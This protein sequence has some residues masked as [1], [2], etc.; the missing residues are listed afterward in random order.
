MYYIFYR[1][2]MFYKYVIKEPNPEI[3]SSA[4][5]SMLLSFNSIYLISLFDVEI[6]KELWIIVGCIFVIIGYV[7]L[8]TRKTLEKIEKKW[9]EESSIR[10]TIKGIL[11]V[12]YFFLSFFLFFIAL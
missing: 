8:F 6:F 3:I 4:F 1:I 9:N 11:I 5:L 2:A 12:I 7:F 10:R